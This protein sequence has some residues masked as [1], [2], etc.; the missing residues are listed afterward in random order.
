[1]KGILFLFIFH[2]VFL[3]IVLEMDLIIWLSNPD[4]TLQH[5][6]TVKILYYMSVLHDCLL[7]TWSGLQGLYAHKNLH[8]IFRSCVLPFCLKDYSPAILTTL[9]HYYHS[10]SCLSFK[11]K[12]KWTLSQFSVSHHSLLN[13]TSSCTYSSKIISPC[14]RL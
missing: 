6:P 10:K 1:M 8:V 4:R 5:C 9:P 3:V 14:T 7:P 2:S 11:S 12:F 13:K